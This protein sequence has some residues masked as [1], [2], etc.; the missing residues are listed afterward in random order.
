MAHH[1]VLQGQQHSGQGQQECSW[2]NSSGDTS[3]SLPTVSKYFDAPCFCSLPPTGSLTAHTH[4]GKATRKA[5]RALSLENSS[6]RTLG[7]TQRW[8]QVSQGELRAETSSTLP[9]PAGGGSARL[10]W[11]HALNAPVRPAFRSILRPRTSALTAPGEVK[12]QQPRLEPFSL[13]N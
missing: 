3:C 11:L 2:P 6:A 10:V 5:Q 13:A 4:L 9:G 12:H 1:P 8:E 7:S